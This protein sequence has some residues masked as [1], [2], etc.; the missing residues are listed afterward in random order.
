MPAV[1]RF[2]REP[3]AG[4][5]GSA[6]SATAGEPGNLPREHRGESVHGRVDVGV[7]EPDVLP[8]RDRC[9]RR[10]EVVARQLR[11]LVEEYR[12]DPR[13]ASKGRLYLALSP[14]W[15]PVQRCGRRDRAEPSRA[16][17]G[18]QCAATA[19]RGADR[20]FPVGSRWYRSAG[21]EDL[22]RPE[23]SREFPVDEHGDAVTVTA[24][25]VDEYQ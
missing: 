25:V 3:S 13:A 1:P 15:T 10:R 4:A 14:L 2:L 20:R 8:L 5:T 6:W 9:Q 17:D 16:D 18:D 23:R 21:P 12:D 22:V 11:G 24:Q 19:Q 7:L